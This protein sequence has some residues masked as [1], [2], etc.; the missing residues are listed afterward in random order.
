MRGMKCTQIAKEALIKEM[1][2]ICIRILGEI[3]L[4]IRAEL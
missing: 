3:T 4:Q 1:V 2:R